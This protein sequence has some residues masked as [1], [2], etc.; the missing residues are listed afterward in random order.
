LPPPGVGS[1]GVPRTGTRIWFG[2]GSRIVDDLK[3]IFRRFGSAGGPVRS[4]I[5][6]DVDSISTTGS[7][8]LVD[9]LDVTLPLVV[10]GLNVDDVLVLLDDVVGD[11]EVDELVVLL[12]VLVLVECDV[13]VDDVVGVMP[14]VLVDVLLLVDVV[15]LV[16]DVLLVDEVVG[17]CEVELD[18]LDDVVVLLDVLVLVERDVLVDDV[19]GASEVELDEL[20]LLVVGTVLDDVELLVEVVE[21]PHGPVCGPTLA[22]LAGS[23]P[24]SISRRSYVPSRSRSMPMRVP[25]P[26][27][28]H[29]YVSSW[30]AVPAS[31][32]RLELEMTPSVLRSGWKLL[33]PT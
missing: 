9:V 8:V 5:V 29:V 31:A 10:V 26:T 23:K 32:R 14:V 3:T 33:L 20:V 25:D 30:P 6:S 15:L 19:V 21:P 13:L 12:D 18:V 22:G 17:A 4:F 24:Q 1:P 7:V 2:P 11:V 28:T 27:G 16:L